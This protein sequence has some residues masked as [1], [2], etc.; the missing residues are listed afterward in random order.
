MSTKT[1]DLQAEWHQA[2]QEFMTVTGQDLG[3]RSPTA[4]QITA[5]LDEL[6][7]AKDVESYSKV[8]KAK[9]AVGNTMRAIQTIG[10][11]LAQGAQMTGF[12]GPANMAMNCVS[13]FID[14]GLRTRT[15][16]TTSRTFLVESV[17]SWNVW[18]FMS[19]TAIS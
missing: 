6:Q 3:V 15:L 17:P 5:K 7:E 18:R 16:P 12:G 19:R 14:A 4:E 8:G 1:F 10:G 13:F 11:L 9:H 2:C